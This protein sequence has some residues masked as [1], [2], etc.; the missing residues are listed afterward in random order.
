MNNSSTKLGKRSKQSIN[1]G[2]LS[3]N[4]KTPLTPSSAIIFTDLKESSKIWNH[5]QNKG[6]NKKVLGWI[7]M[8]F[9]LIN[10]VVDQFNEDCE[11]FV[12]KTMGD[13][14]M[15]Y[16]PWELKKVISFSLALQSHV[17]DLNDSI[18]R[19]SS[20]RTR[21]TLTAISKR[22][23]K[24]YLV[25]RKG[26]PPI[27]FSVRIGFCYGRFRTLT[28]SIQNCEF[29]DFFGPGVNLASHMESKICEVPGGIAFTVYSPDSSFENSQ[30]LIREAFKNEELRET[31]QKDQYQCYAIQT[32]TGFREINVD[33]VPGNIRYNRTKRNDALNIVM[34]L[35]NKDTFSGT[36][37]ITSKNKCL[38]LIGPKGPRFDSL[39]NT[40]AQRLLSRRRRVL[41]LYT[42]EDLKCRFY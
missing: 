25:S 18:Y 8:Y 24:P 3:K 6:W 15:I 26:E 37:T 28:S 29:T 34:I 7:H 22:F 35:P 38:D 32:T 23:M 42:L 13:I 21:N 10:E 17:K 5:C 2:N 20:P 9:K 40:L 39:K 4:V 11:G 14:C 31:L 36:H 41:C 33:S 1:L 27:F 30:K 12:V 16:C 19:H